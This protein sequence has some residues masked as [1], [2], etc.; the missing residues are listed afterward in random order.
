MRKFAMLLL[1]PAA[2]MAQDQ[3]QAL[4]ERACTKCHSINATIRQRNSKDRWQDVVD[5]M[6]SRGAELTDPEAE[7]LIDYLA[8]T[9]GPRVNVN[10]A[11]AGDIAKAL[12]VST[13]TATAV[14][15]YRTKHGAFKTIEDLKAVPALSGKDIESKKG[16]LDFAQ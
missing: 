11:A 8:K 12:D 1:L 9:Y 13:E 16:G 5:N 7:R 10:K 2:A 3:G 6:I 4:I 14:I 15:E